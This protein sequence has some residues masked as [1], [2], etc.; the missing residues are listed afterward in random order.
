MKT[1]ND[2]MKMYT[3]DGVEL[4]SIAAMEVLFVCTNDEGKWYV[5]GR[6]AC[7]VVSIATYCNHLELV[8]TTRRAAD[9]KCR[10]LNGGEK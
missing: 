8:F 9:A 5:K 7:Q 6:D 4:G 3:G 1:L 2:V 10:E